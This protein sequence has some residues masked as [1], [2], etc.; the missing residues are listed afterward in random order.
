MYCE[1]KRRPDGLDEQ[2]R[3]GA[4]FR[5]PFA[6]QD[7]SME[8]SEAPFRRR[9]CWMARSIFLPISCLFTPRSIAGTSVTLRPIAASRSS[10]RSKCWRT[11]C[12]ELDCAVMQCESLRWNVRVSRLAVR[13]NTEKTMTTKRIDR[14][15]V[16]NFVVEHIGPP[17][18]ETPRRKIFPQAGRFFFTTE[19]HMREV[20]H[21]T[22][23]A[24]ALR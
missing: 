9:G 2:I 7:Y 6:A 19:S 5:T 12:G 15:A 14:E 22:F 18:L 3:N 23:V 1:R 11:A 10:A 21:E 4:R 17:R 8:L 13:A 20:D 16:T 24:S